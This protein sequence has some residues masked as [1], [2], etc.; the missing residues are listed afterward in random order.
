MLVDA[1]LLFESGFDKECD[2]IISVTADKELR[3]KRI[4]VR[5]GIDDIAATKRIESQ[6]A[7]EYLIKHSDYN[8]VNNGDLYSLESE[9]KMVAEKVNNT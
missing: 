4:M 3:K 1:P 5:D 6:L 8:I 2:L 7:D 9:V